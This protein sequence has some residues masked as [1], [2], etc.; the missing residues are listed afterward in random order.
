MLG[1]CCAAEEISPW[2]STEDSSGHS[3]T[4]YRLPVRDLP[5]SATSTARAI[6]QSAVACWIRLVDKVQ[7]LLS[8]LH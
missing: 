7:V 1:C 2:R 6:K 5:I 8:W 3:C 4:R